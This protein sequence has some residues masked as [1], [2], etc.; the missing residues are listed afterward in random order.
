MNI[1]FA[2][3]QDINSWMDLLNL[4]KDSFPGL[5]IPEYKAALSKCILNKE[6][7]VA[8]MGNTVVGALSFSYSNAELNFLAVH[9]QYRKKGIAKELI[10]KLF[11]LFSAGTELSVITYREGDLQGIYARQLYQRMGFCYGELLTMFDYPCQR[12]IYTVK[13]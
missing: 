1:E 6:A 4:V 7:I 5:D 9:P 12:M 10:L 11:S 3:E 2:Q 8:K 13:R